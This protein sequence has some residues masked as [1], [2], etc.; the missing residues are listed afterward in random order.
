[1]NP[2]IIKNITGIQTGQLFPSKKAD[3][4]V[5]G[6]Y[7]KSPINENNVMGHVMFGVI[8]EPI[9]ST[10]IDGKIAMENYKIPTIDER[11][12]SETC[13]ELAQGVWDRVAGL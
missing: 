4:L 2:Q 7:P 6:Y 3:L 11:E 13:Q 1:V 12:I 5:S 9:H 8:H 10:I